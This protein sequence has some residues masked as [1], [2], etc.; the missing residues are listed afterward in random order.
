M[1]LQVY[2]TNVSS[3]QNSQF[4]SNEKRVLEEIE[5]IKY[6]QSLQE[7]EKD[8]PFILISNTHTKP[9]QVPKNI[10]DKSVLLIHPNSG[11][12]NISKDFLEKH[13]FP[14]ILGNPIR[15][16]AVCEYTLSCIFN[17]FTKIPNHQFWPN[18]RSWNR[19]LLRDQKVL[20]LG[21]GHIGRLLQESLTPICRQVQVFDPKINQ[22]E[23]KNSDLKNQWSDELAQDTNI[24]IVAA[25]LTKTSQNMVGHKIFNKL[26]TEN[27]IINPARGEIINEAELIQYLTKNPK[28]FCYLDVFQ[29]EPFDPGHLSDI[30][31]VNKT[32]H[33]AGVYDRL[34]RDIISFEYLIIK[35]FVEAFKNDNIQRFKQE[36]QDCILNF[37]HDK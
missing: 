10:L 35:D 29:Q 11:H 33:I 19:K 16:N 21:Y 18:S 4:L 34:N 13:S 28:S 2:R 3:Y 25:S 6:I 22:N 24:L 15:A 23:I 36:Y 14:V 1:T 37:D 9:E 5:G 12:D 17:H 20:I 30:K 26:A 27:M 31:N 8:S 7:L 32:A